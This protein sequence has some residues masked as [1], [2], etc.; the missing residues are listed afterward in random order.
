MDEALY[1]YFP[2]RSAIHR[3]TSYRPMPPFTKGLCYTILLAMLR[4]KLKGLVT[5]AW[6]LRAAPAR[7]AEYRST[8]FSVSRIRVG[9]AARK[10]KRVRIALWRSGL[11]TRF[12]VKAAS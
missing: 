4:R 8:N 3:M 10:A 2:I 9:L 1:L 6:R 12:S 11:E 7:P 5:P